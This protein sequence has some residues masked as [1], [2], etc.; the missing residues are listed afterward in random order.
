MIPHRDGIA[1]GVEGDLWIP[2]ITSIVGF[3]QLRRAP[4]IRTGGIAVCPDVVAGSV[5]LIPHRDG[6]AVG[7][8]GD[9]WI[10]GTP[11][12]VGFNQFGFLPA[13]IGLR[14]IASAASAGREGE[15]RNG[16]YE[17]KPGSGMD[18]GCFLDHVSL[19]VRM[20]VSLDTAGQNPIT[21]PG[22]LREK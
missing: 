5:V 2:G 16:E 4:G 6:I 21:T 9:L 13:G 1:V 20:V 10:I 8:D 12:I 14:I 22:E 3:D 19:L 15:K 18:V 7:V 17:I 11:G